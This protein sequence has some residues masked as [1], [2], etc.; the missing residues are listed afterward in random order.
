MKK[1]ALVLLAMVML[2]GKANANTTLQYAY[3]IKEF[4]IAPVYSS[5]ESKIEVGKCLLISVEDDG[6]GKIFW[7]ITVIDQ[8]DPEKIAVIAYIRSPDEKCI[9]IDN[10]CEKAKAKFVAEKNKREKEKQVRVRK[11]EERKTKESEARKAKIDQFPIHIQNAINQGSVLIGMTQE[12]AKLAW[13]NPNHINRTITK[14]GVSEQW[15]YGEHNYLYFENG[16][17]TVIQN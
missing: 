4:S 1:I 13:G 14:F 5:F 11:E 16:V 17:L 7:P 2:S 10:S 3:V 15:V 12:Q 6:F 8:N 9:V